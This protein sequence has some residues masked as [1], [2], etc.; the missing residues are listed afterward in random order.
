MSQQAQVYATVLYAT[1]AW[2]LAGQSTL[3]AYTTNTRKK[4]SSLT[5]HKL[6]MTYFHHKPI[7]K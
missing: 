1:V 7:K 5:L 3:F 2:R 4:N 6:P